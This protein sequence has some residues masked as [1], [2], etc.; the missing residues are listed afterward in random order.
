MSSSSGSSGND[1]WPLLEMP[2]METKSSAEAMRLLGECIDEL[3]DGPVKVELIGDSASQFGSRNQHGATGSPFGGGNQH[4]MTGHKFGEQTASNPFSPES[5]QRMIEAA[6]EKARDDKEKTIVDLV[7][8]M[9]DLTIKLADLR[10]MRDQQK[11]P[12]F[13]ESLSKLEQDMEKESNECLLASHKALKSIR[14][15]D[16]DLEGVK[17]NLEESC[18]LYKLLQDTEASKRQKQQQYLPPR[19]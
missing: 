19:A 17:K 4:G 9:T 7:F 2:V 10:T 1:G 13:K 12:K 18:E 11:D 15:G 5:M 8:K 3:K 14:H 16:K 6:K